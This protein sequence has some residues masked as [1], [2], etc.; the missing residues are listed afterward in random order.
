MSVDN[1]LSYLSVKS[2][3]IAL[4]VASATFVIWRGTRQRKVQN[5][6][7]VAGLFVYPIKSLRGIEVGTVEVTRSGIKYG[8][9]RDREMMLING[10]NRM[11]SLRQDPRLALIHV[12]MTGPSELTL[13]CE[14]HEPLKIRPRTCLDVDEETIKFSVW[15]LPTEGLQV[16]SEA[17]RW[18][19]NFLGLE[20]VKL[21]QHLPTLRMRPAKYQSE[22]GQAVDSRT[23]ILY[24]DDDPVHLTSNDTLSLLNSTLGE[25]F[26]LSH[27]NFR[28]N[29]VI[30]G[31]Q[32]HSEEKW[33][34]I[35]LNG[36]WMQKVKLCDRCFIPTID[37]ERGKRIDEKVHILKKF[38]SAESEIE[39][40]NYGSSAI[41]G[42]M[43]A[44]MNDGF[45]SIGA[46]IDAYE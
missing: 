45:L 24:Q 38:R 36:I 21:V 32:P 14:G 35:S 31:T 7:R 4:S 23:L 3:L 43:F 33:T 18:F 15:S 28:P 12:D 39:K 10:E 29:I 2:S 9:F 11:I 5:A 22:A 42:V 20:G 27:Q 25:E 46:S 6:A 8:V 41:F 44:P 37:I 1:L 17:S 13:T 26:V 30:E 40:K 16:S 34:G 19:S